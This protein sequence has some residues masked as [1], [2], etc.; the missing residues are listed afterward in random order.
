MN[1]NE[2]LSKLLEDPMAVPDAELLGVLRSEYPYMTLPAALA[3][4]RG[5][6]EMSA[7][8]RR[9]LMSEVS[10]NAS[11]HDVL[12]RLIDPDGCRLN[13]MSA[14]KDSCPAQPTTDKAIDTFLERYGRMDSREEALLERMIFNPVPDYASMLEREERE[15]REIVKA[16]TTGSDQDRKLDAYLRGGQ[17]P[18]TDQPLHS[19][20]P[21]AEQK[22]AEA[23]PDKKEV[24]RKAP[25]ADH[26]RDT[27]GSLS[28]S[29][30]QIYI[31]Q[32]KFDKAYDIIHTLSLN[33][34][35]KSVY[36]ADQLRFLQ[37][38]MLNHRYK[39]D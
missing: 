20:A 5:A 18:Y 28:E 32:R 31:R 10:L 23:T 13:E 11:G 21:A 4:K 15:E 17:Q 34:P 1:V 24:Q 36:F 8:R 6:A 35:E 3:L 25:A 26:R 37:K 29:L 27:M 9:E 38:L 12:F 22:V 30:A 33:N 19:T 14:E 2:A 39:K 7:E 16:E